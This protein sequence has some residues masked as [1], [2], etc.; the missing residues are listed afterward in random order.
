MC[1]RQVFL[2]LCNSKT[3]VSMSLLG[4]SKTGVSMLG[5]YM[6]GVFY[7]DIKWL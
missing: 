7:V 5:D 2:C 1:L 4:D 6:T 3:G